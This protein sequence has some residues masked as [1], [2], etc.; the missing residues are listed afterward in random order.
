V[1]VG[2]QDTEDLDWHLLVVPS[3]RNRWGVSVT[4]SLPRSGE[5]G[6]GFIE[7]MVSM[8]LVMLAAAGGIAVL[9]A[10]IQ[11]TSF[12]NGIQGASRLGQDVIDRAM[13][14][15]FDSL[16]GTSSDPV[17]KAPV[18]AAPITASPQGASAG[19][20]TTYTRNC[21]ATTFSTNYKAIRVTVDWTD[22]RD[23]RPH[24]VIL[25][26]QRAR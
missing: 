4:H 14:E 21:Y 10:T 15:P 3:V 13:A 12:A 24:R 16:T 26:M 25:G 23:N 1:I 8:L 6:F 2:D 19:N 9:G 7:V 18:D 22:S 5:R 17:C 20:F 11:A